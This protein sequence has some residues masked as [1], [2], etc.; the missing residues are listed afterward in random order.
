ML[1]SF[2]MEKPLVPVDL[3]EHGLAM[4]LRAQVGILTMKIWSTCIPLSQT[5][6]QAPVRILLEPYAIH[7]EKTVRTMQTGQFVEILS[8]LKFGRPLLV[9]WAL[10]S[11]MTK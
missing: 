6:I 3:M 11:L 7:K 10:D 4:H 8:L 1:V 5:C 9:G 2:S